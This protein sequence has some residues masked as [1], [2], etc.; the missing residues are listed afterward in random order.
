M[1]WGRVGRE[2]APAV[3]RR[4]AV[5]RAAGLEGVRGPAA[6][7]ERVVRGPVVVGPVVVGPAGGGEDLLPSGSEAQR[8]TRSV[9]HGVTA[10]IQTLGWHGQVRWPVTVSG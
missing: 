3:E 6:E 2:R 5:R 1:E 10:R 9:E 8:R 4:A 7:R